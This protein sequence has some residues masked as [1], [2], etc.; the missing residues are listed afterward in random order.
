[1]PLH[2]EFIGKEVT[3]KDRNVSGTIIDETKHS[4]IIQTDRGK[5]TI[6]KGKAVFLF[7]AN[8]DI[9]MIEGKHIQQRPEDRIK[10]KKWK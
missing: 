1:M 5:K 10:P 2:R 3:I 7:R 8:K 9:V 6:L 4:F